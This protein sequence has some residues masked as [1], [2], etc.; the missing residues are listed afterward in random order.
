MNG[1][2]I[3]VL[4]QQI[5]L[6]SADLSALLGVSISTLYRWE[7][8]NAVPDPRTQA[9]LLVLRTLHAAGKLPPD[10]TT[11]V[12]C[13]GGLYALYRVLL[14]FFALEAA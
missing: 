7:A 12:A 5:G 2:E 3:K 1:D 6:S 14:A 11:L 10:L 9:V 8:S 13:R 4:R